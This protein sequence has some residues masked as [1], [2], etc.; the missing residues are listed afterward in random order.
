MN[1]L[2]LLRIALV[3]LVFVGVV[4]HGPS[5]VNDADEM[6]FAGNHFL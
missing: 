1:M 4:R 2:R 5:R 3:R 6:G